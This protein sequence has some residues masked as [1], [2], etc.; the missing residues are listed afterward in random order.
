M[1]WSLQVF[2]H[3]LD[4]ILKGKKWNAQYVNS[5]YPTVII[6]HE[7]KIYLDTRRKI[8]ALFPDFVYVD[9][10]PGTEFS[11][12]IRVGIVGGD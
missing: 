9:F 2:K 5:P 12:G 8:L 1:G 10:H 4:G 7:G 3:E 6:E 11:V